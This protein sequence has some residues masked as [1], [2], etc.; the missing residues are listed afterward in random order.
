MTTAAA[1]ASTLSASTARAPVHRERAAR[2]ATGAVV[3]LALVL[4]ELQGGFAASRFAPVGVLVVWAAVL[5]WALARRPAYPRHLRAALGAYALLTLWTAASVLWADTPGRAFDAVGRTALYG[6]VLA[7]VLVPR[8]P[9][10]SITRLLA[11]VGAGTTL[12]AAITLLRITGAEDPSQWFIDG[13]LIAPAGYVNATAALW[14]IALP[15]LVGLAAGEARHPAA[16]VAALVAASLLLQTAL[17][18]QS[19]GGMLALVVGL[20]VLLV[21]TPRRGPTLLTIA[22]LVASVLP[23]ASTLLDVRGAPDVARLASRLDDAGHAM[24]LGLIAVAAIAAAWQLVLAHLPRRTRAGLGGAALGDRVAAGLVVL[25]LVALVAAVGNPFSWAVDRADDA[26]NGGYTEVAATG[27]R[28]T[29]SLGSNRGDMYRVALRTFADHPLRGVGAE[30]FQPSY[31]RD[32]R[33]AE[34]PRYAHSLQLGVLAGL[35]LIGG[36]LALVAYGGVMAGALRR[37]E[38]SR[39]TRA[40]VALAFSAFAVWLAGASWDWTWEFPAVTMLA[41]VLLGAAARATDEAGEAPSRELRAIRAR[42]RAHGIHVEE[43][44]EEPVDAVPRGRRGRPLA[45]AVLAAALAVTVVTVVLGA[46]SYYLR[47]GTAAAASDPSSAT[48]DLARA[49]RLN[50]LDSDALLSRAIVVRR[51]GDP[52]AWRRDLAEVLR[53]SPQDW[54]AHVESALALAGAGDRAGAIA[55]LGIARRLNPQQPVVGEAIDALRA[56]RGVDPATVESRIA[57]AQSARLQPIGPS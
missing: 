32:R 8:W 50:P 27:D 20:G 11:L 49:A 38:R 6:A 55:Q 14:T 35:G 16:R 26:L 25:G 24:V 42:A 21:L 5:A 10:A 53:R 46:S 56:G 43:D 17:L 52:A 48:L 57:G 41:L 33:S 23:A 34:S 28:L 4:G 39:R 36:V 51:L 44:D 9:R 12:L 47:R 31:L 15:P 45:V 29:G 18:S 19:R 2:A 22:A 54:F 1:P 13:R 40:S 7:L 37:R 30:D 3:V